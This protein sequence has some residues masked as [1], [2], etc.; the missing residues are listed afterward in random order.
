MPNSFFT[1]D[2]LEK[3]FD[4]HRYNK[5]NLDIILEAYDL[6]KQITLIKGF[7]YD[8]KII[9]K[10]KN[11]SISYLYIDGDHSYSGCYNDLKNWYPKMKKGGLIIGDD[12]NLNTIK[13]A[14][15][16]FCRIENIQYTENDNKFYF[17]K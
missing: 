2:S 17:V 8:P 10:F 4:L 11:A 15:K 1:G 5:K 12:G 9:E 7:S 13:E 6:K 16:D 3:F 14:V